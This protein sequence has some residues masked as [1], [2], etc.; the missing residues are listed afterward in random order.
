[1]KESSVIFRPSREEN[2]IFLGVATRHDDE[3]Y[4]RQ[5]EIKCK[6]KYSAADRDIYGFI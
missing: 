6:N 1:M 5:T 2:I 4:R 3:K